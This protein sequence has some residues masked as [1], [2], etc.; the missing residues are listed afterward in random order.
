ME[1]MGCI[2]SMEDRVSV[3]LEVFIAEQVAAMHSASVLERC[4]PYI[5]SGA[6][7]DQSVV[8]YIN[9]G[10][11]KITCPTCSS[12]Q[13]AHRT[14]RRLWCENCLNQEHAALWL[15]VV[16]PPDAMVRDIERVLL[17]RPDPATRN[18]RSPETV[19]GLADENRAHGYV[20]A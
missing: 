10:G 4:W 13:L 14:T 18:W 9:H 16:W 17:L 5:R 11:W 8:P 19:E 15:S 6:L 2:Y 3:P 20:M 1:P 7:C 12:A